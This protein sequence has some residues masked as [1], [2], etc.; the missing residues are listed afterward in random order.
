LKTVGGKAWDRVQERA[1]EF[2]KEKVSFT[3]R[4]KRSDQI[5]GYSGCL[6]GVD[7]EYMD[8]KLSKYEPFTITRT[9]QPKPS[10]AP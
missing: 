1:P 10:D 4:N 9:E 7:N 8:D 2:I 5:P 3:S 6:N